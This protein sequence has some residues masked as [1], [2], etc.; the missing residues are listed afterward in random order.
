MDLEDRIAGVVLA[1][2]ELG[3]LERVDVRLDLRELRLELPEGL[4]IALL[5]ELE[6]DLRFVSA[7]PL[8]LP[9]FDGGPDCRRLTPDGLGLV[10]VPPEVRGGRLLAQLDGTTLERR[11]VKGASRAPSRARRARGRA[12]AT[13]RAG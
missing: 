2:E 4:R 9:A 3:Q 7:L 12:R 6:K 10:G 8:L 1:A 5:R 11:Q 13:R